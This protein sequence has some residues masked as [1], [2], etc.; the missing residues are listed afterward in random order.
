MKFLDIL[1]LAW[2]NLRRRKSRTILTSIGVMIGC[3]SIVVMVSIGSGLDESMQASLANMGDLTMINLYN[4][5][6]M[7]TDKSVKLDD[8][9]MQTI[10]SIDHVEAASPK[11]TVD[12]FSTELSARNGRYVSGWAGLTGISSD[13]IEAM[14]LQTKEGDTDLSKPMQGSIPVLA[15]NMKAYDFQD[16]MRP[17]GSNMI[18]YWTPEYQEALMNGEDPTASLPDPYFDI[19]NEKMTLSVSSWDENGSSTPQTYTLQPVG[20]LE[21]NDSMYETQNG[22]IMDLEQM[23]KIIKDAQKASGTP[24]PPTNYQDVLVKADSIDNVESVENELRSLG[25][26]NINS[27]VSIRKS[28][29]EQ[30]R[31]IQLVLGGI[32][33]VALI[34]AAIG[35]TNTMIMS[36]S[37]RTK[38]IGIMKALGCRTKDIRLIFLSEA[39]I[40]GLIGGI[41]GAVLSF[42]ISLIINY[43]SYKMSGK[44]ISFME[45]LFTPGSRVSVIPWWLMLFGLAFSIGVGLLSGSYPAKK[46]VRIP[47]LEAI[48][49]E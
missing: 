44:D 8:E 18:D 5:E 20:L 10:R 14:N 42:S 47:A 21:T 16:S 12:N 28:M 2:Q 41:L 26:S 46:A 34:V 31:M 7:D 43:I 32:G 29:T 35:I 39:G 1:K 19:M 30:A 3:T 22:I 24:A 36:I 48:K 17:E 37:E 49:H 38:E 13:M 4:Y 45:A 25:F 9:M 27:L 23:K 11:L 6:G 15:G 40:I 33:A